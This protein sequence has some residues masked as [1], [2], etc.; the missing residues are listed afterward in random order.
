VRRDTFKTLNIHL[1]ENGE[2]GTSKRNAFSPA[3]L[4]SQL[5]GL[6]VQ[7]LVDRSFWP[8]EMNNDNLY[9]CETCR[10]MQ[11]ATVK[12]R[13]WVFVCRLL[14]PFAAPKVDIIKAPDY[15]MVMLIAPLRQ[16]EE[17]REGFCVLMSRTLLKRLPP[18]ETS[19]GKDSD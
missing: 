16:N 7:E 17:V 13:K 12:V 10:S 14:I 9:A 18:S 15:L 6:S 4:L 19:A 2:A 5:A 8:E 3:T 11:E 1:K